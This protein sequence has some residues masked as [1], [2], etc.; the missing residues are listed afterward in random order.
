MPL[1]P[2]GT[3]WPPAHMHDIFNAM[4]EW[5]AWWS[6][7][8]DR[9][10]E[11]YGAG[12]P[13]TR[14]SAGRTGLVGAFTK[15][16][17][18]K[19]NTNLEKPLH[20]LHVPVASDIC[21]ASADLLFSEP[22][23]ITANN[24]R[25]TER[26]ALI[27]DEH[28]EQLLTGA[29]ESAAAL[30]GVYLRANW[31]DSTRKNVFITAMDADKAIPE[32]SWGILT[33]VTFWRV[34]KTD[35]QIVWRHLERHELDSF[36]IGVIA[37]GLYQ[38]STDKLGRAMALADHAATADLP[39][40]EAGTISTGTPGLAV[41]YIANQTPNRAW[42]D[43][44]IGVHLG[45]SDLDNVCAHMDALDETMSSWMRDVRQGKARLIVP[46]SMLQ[47]IGPGQGAAFDIDQDIYEA[48]NAA[49][50]RADSNQLS[51][52]SVQFKIRTEEHKGTFD[53]LLATIYRTAGY[54]AQT[55]GEENDTRGANMTATE[56]VARE[57][58][59]F[60]TRDR[61]IRT[62]KAGLQRILRKAVLM[63]ASI[64]GGTVPAD[65][66]V[67]VEFGD[68]IQDSTSVRAQN[69]QLMYASQS[70][71]TKTR[72]EELH[73]DWDE[74]RVLIEVNTIRAENSLPP[75]AD[76]DEV[77]EDGQQ[78]STSVRAPE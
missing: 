30:G 54:S 67:D 41:E 10:H 6:N 40:N 34:V 44:P 5:A 18:G 16:F 59:S 43:H 14:P 56:V 37:H 49:P 78:L 61:K 24:P 2:N 32:F 46:Q 35:G 4:T 29:A 45:R 69:A 51:L 53:Q 33:A 60:L 62:F 3:N 63:D 75:L 66:L 9:L 64:F 23:T 68:S 42:R 13:R 70:G 19:K 28:F 27:A 36:G 48:V 57:R 76:P 55:F 17:W 72:V 25:A 21:Q 52:E 31:D 22:A 50:G 26:L 58:R 65:V 7:D 77:G 73:P 39:V 11:L 12:A 38:G 20:K 15:F 71:S 74:K 47:V 1:P 8:T